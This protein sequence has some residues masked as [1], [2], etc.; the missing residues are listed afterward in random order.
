MKIEI[1]IPEPP[2]GWVFDKFRQA[3]PGE[4]RWDGSCWVE[5]AFGTA[6]HYLVCVKSEPQWRPATVTDEGKQARFWD[7]EASGWTE[8]KLLHVDVPGSR[9]PYLVL[10]KGS[11]E[12]S[13]FDCCEV[14]YES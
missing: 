8:G 6:G 10:P 14:L 11:V 12:A 13:W 4:C 1:E 5:G 9:I 3:K 7:G 2:E